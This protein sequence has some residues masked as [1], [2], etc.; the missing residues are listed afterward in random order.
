MQ[1]PILLSDL[2]EHGVLTLTL[3]RPDVRNALNTTLQRLLA[4]AVAAAADDPA[5]RVVVLAGAGKAFCAGGDAFAAR[6]VDEGDPLLARWGDSPLWMDHELRVQRLVRAAEAAR[7]LHDMPKPTIARVHAVAA[8][9]GMSLALA[10]DLRIMTPAASLLPAF[11][12][13]ARSGDYGGSWFLARLVGP[14]RA[15]EIYMLGDRIDAD[16]ALRLGIANRVV[17]EAALDTEVA[18]LARRLAA[19]APLAMRY[20]K[21]NMNAALE[22]ELPRFIERESRNMVRCALS[23]DGDEGLAAFN[24]GRDP[25]FTGR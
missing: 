22:E 13:L 2:D 19:G 5:V 4:E 21:D 8:G 17:P 11:A 10:C 6:H 18:A 16:A 25:V 7:L 20:I 12:R 3:N 23:A 14:A 24:A 15:K 1:A 9:A